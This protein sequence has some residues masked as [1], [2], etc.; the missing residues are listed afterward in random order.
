MKRSDYLTNAIFSG[1]NSS[2]DFADLIN[3]PNDDRVQDGLLSGF[4]RAIFNAAVVL[5]HADDPV[6]AFPLANIAFEQMSD[7]FDWEVLEDGEI[8][9]LTSLELIEMELLESAAYCGEIALPLFESVL[10]SSNDVLH[11][12]V[13]NGMKASGD[14][15]FFD[16]IS[17][18]VS[19]LE[20]RAEHDSELYS[21]ADKAMCACLPF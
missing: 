14:Y 12:A 5:K 17:E 18:F 8:D 1:G 19:V 21:V 11:F 20:R 7:P 15:V 2:D 16:L 10:A 4:T 6:D 9:L 13:L 3:D